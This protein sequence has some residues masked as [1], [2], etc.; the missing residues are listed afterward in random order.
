MSPFFFSF[1][2]KTLIKSLHRVTYFLDVSQGSQLQS[3]I[4]D[5]SEVWCLCEGEM[6]F[7]HKLKTAKTE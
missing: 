1:Y 3:Q 4:N 5:N 2:S 7:K 6:N